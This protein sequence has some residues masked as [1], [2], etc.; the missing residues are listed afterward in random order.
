MTIKI[1]Y[2]SDLH[3]E[4]RCLT[5]IPKLL[6]NIG[7]DVLCLAGDIVTVNDKE[8]FNKFVKFL[9]YYSPKYLYLV[10]ISGNHE[11]YHNDK[12]QPIKA[13]C[14]DMVHK[15]LKLLNKTFPNYLY[16][17]CDTVTLTINNSQYMFIGCTLW[18]KVPPEK[19]E[20]IESRMNDYS[21]VYVNKNNEVVKFDISEMQRLHNRHFMF[22][23]R[24]VEI[25]T[26][27][28]IPS[29]LMTHHK[30]ITDAD[31]RQSELTC[32]YESDITKIIKPI[33]KLAVHGHTH[34]HYNKEY[35][36]T[37]YVSNPRG[38][39]SQR[40]MFKPDLAITLE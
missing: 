11:S 18:T 16:L 20:M 36:K 19:Y 6:K 32:A 39:P 26:K 25:A 4:F 1:Q 22:I 24:S 35:N 5:E 37:L 15:K 23:K 8:D 30:P 27:L 31:S 21:H 3:L 2:V 40:T 17:N 33:V 38:Y 34:K 7:A 9:E 10:M 13:N 12:S 14:M 29:I 28:N